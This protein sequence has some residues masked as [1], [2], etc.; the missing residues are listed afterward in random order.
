MAKGWEKTGRKQP[1]ETTAIAL[2]P[3]LPASCRRTT[4]LDWLVIH[5]AI[6]CGSWSSHAHVSSVPSSP[7]RWR[8]LALQKHWE[9]RWGCSKGCRAKLSG[10]TGAP[11]L[12][13][14]PDHPA[15]GFAGPSQS[16][17]S[18]PKGGS[19]YRGSSSR[20]TLTCALSGAFVSCFTLANHRV[21]ASWESCLLSKLVLKPVAV[22]GPQL[23]ASWSQGHSEEPQWVQAG[24]ECALEDSHLNR[25][26]ACENP[27][28]FY[29]LGMGLSEI[30]QCDH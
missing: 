16:E 19:P 21:G 8:D 15:R 12:Q 24:L 2:G 6:Y 18:H 5:G 27:N 7:S 9:A 4:C 23:S 11:G 17:E 29:L 26:T 25:P 13:V 30:Y 1:Q 28:P 20:A 14:Q 22:D 3:A 10:T